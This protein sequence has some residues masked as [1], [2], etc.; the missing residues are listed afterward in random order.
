MRCSNSGPASDACDAHAESRVADLAARL[1]LSVVSWMVRH[2]MLLITLA[3]ALYVTLP[4]LAP[5]LLYR[6]HEAGGRLLYTLFRP[7]CHQLHERSFFVFGEQWTYSAS[8]LAA[9][10][11]GSVPARFVGNQVMGYKMAVCQRDVAIYGSMLLGLM[12]LGPVA[13]RLRMW[14]AR[15]LAMAAAPL[16][17]DGLGQ[18]VGLWHSS[19]WSRVATGVLFGVGLVRWGV[20]HLAR[21]LC[22]AREVTSQS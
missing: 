13:N 10:L 14:P 9:R 1:T 8:E 22:S 6:G 3:M 15:A 18:L 4:V 20:P 16:A 12:V 5:W 19:P 21:A 11:G 7:L 17:I 2:L